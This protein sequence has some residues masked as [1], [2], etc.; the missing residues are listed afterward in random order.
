[1]NVGILL[2]THSGIGSALLNVVT[3]TFGL[4][5]LKVSQLSVNRDP[6]PEILIT[7]ASYLIKQLNK[8]SGVLILTDMFGSTPSNISQ[9]LQQQGFQIK[10][11][12]GLNLPMLFKILTYPHLDLTNL[13]HKAVTGGTEGIFESYPEYNQAKSKGKM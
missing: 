8:G 7:K 4:L 9:I 2:I 11:V 12:T 3:G 13:A 5:P 10:V 6:D 1:M